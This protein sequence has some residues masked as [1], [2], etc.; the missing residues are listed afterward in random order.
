S[1]IE[2]SALNREARQQRFEQAL[3][4]ICMKYPDDIE[5]KLLFASEHLGSKDPYSIDVILQTVLAAA[6]H[7]PGALHYRI[8]LWDR[9]EPQY[10]LSNSTLYGS[11]ATSA[12]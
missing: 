10:I 4:G 9:K 1:W 11:I 12:A 6:P 7:H 3:Q 8:H 2:D 5:A